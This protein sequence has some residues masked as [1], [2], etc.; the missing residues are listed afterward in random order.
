MNIVSWMFMGIKYYETSMS[1]MAVYIIFLEIVLE[2]QWK[3][4]P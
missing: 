4:N 3:K 1:G 2:Q